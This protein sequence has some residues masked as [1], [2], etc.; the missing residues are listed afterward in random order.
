MS[1]CFENSM[2]DTVFSYL[3]VLASSLITVDT[4]SLANG[5]GKAQQMNTLDVGK[6]AQS[7]GVNISEYPVIR[8]DRKMIL[9][10]LLQR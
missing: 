4:L 7:F 5:A 10:R 3:Y 2:T 1:T 6:T 9:T 8:L